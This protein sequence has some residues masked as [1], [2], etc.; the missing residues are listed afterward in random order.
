MSD[1]EG[2]GRMRV[3]SDY[4]EDGRMR[5]LLV[6][7][8]VLLAI[9]AVTVCLVVRTEG[10]RSAAEDRIGRLLG[11]DVRV[12]GARMTWPCTL[13]L[14]D[15]GTRGHVEGQSAGFGASEVRI[16]PAWRSRWAVEVRRGTL[17]L[18]QAERAPWQPAF[19]AR[20]GTLAERDVR[21]VG[22]ITEAFRE[23]V[24]LRV[25]DGRMEWVSAAGQV[26]ARAAGI[27]FTVAPV[28]LPGRRVYYH[29][30][31]VFEFRGPRGAELRDES[32]EWL[33][34]DHL[35]YVELSHTAGRR[36]T[37]A[38]PDGERHE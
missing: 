37:D 20:L 3:S 14:E 11:L 10:A 29:W 6:T 26:Q 5:R 8:G 12:G 23:R 17:T 13:V 18:V 38:L 7:L 1:G 33:T 2:R 24:Q 34:A 35:E 28:K 19:F 32:W 27:R 30:L 21:E 25:M 36:L 15:V 9:A 4:R 16:T 22:R 31:T